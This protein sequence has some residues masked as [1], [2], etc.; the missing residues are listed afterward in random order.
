MRIEKFYLFLQAIVAVML[1]GACSEY[2]DI[3]TAETVMHSMDM[4]ASAL[5]VSRDDKKSLTQG[6][7]KIPEMQSKMSMD[8][9]MFC[10]YTSVAGINLQKDTMLAKHSRGY[11]VTTDSFYDSYDL[12]TYQYASTETFAGLNSVAATSI[13]PLY[14]D[15][16]VKMVT[17]WSTDRFW[18]GFIYNN[19][20]FAYAPY[21]PVGLTP[22]GFAIAGWPYFHYSVPDDISEQSDLLVSRNEIWTGGVPGVDYANIDVPGD[23]NEPDSIRFDHVCTGIRFAIGDK[24][25]PG[26]IKK[27]EIKNVY[28]EADYWYEDEAWHNLSVIRSFSLEKDFIIQEGE[29]NKILNSKDIFMLIPQ[30]TPS[31]AMIEITIDDGVEHVISISIGNETWQKGHTVTYYLSTYDDKSVYVLAVDPSDEEVSY[32]GGIKNLNISSYKQ[33]YY[34]SQIPVPW[35]LEYTYEIPGQGVSAVQT[36]VSEIITDITFNGNGSVLGENNAIEIAEQY[37]RSKSWRNLHTANLRKAAQVGS[38]ASPYDLTLGKPTANCYVISAPGH[39]KFP[40]VYG[41]ALKANGDFNTDAYGTNTFVDHRDVKINNP[42]IYLTNGG[43]NVPD[44]ACI[45]W[46]DAPQLVTPSSVKLDDDKHYIEFEIERNNIC[47]GNCLLAVRDVN[48]NIMWSWH[49]WVTDHDMEKTVEVHNYPADGGALTS[50]FMDIP[51]GYCSPD[52]RVYD[53]YKIHIKVKQ[54]ETGGKTAACDFYQTSADSLYEYG[55]NCLFYQWGRK[56]PMIGSN[57]MGNYRKPYYDSEY[58]W[59]AQQKTVTTGNGIKTPYIF[60]Y[61]TTK[62]CWAT[63]HK[64][65]FWNKG[66]SSTVISNLPVNKTIYDPTPQYYSVQCDAAVTGFLMYGGISSN[67]SEFNIRGGFDNGWHFYTLGWHMGPTILFPAMGWLNNASSKGG[68]IE[69]VNECPAYWSSGSLANSAKIQCGIEYGGNG[70]PRISTHNASNCDFG[71]AI[72]FVRNEE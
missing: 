49:I 40:L 8:G 46:Q 21:H 4:P 28:G 60:Y 14:T 57:G 54:T 41:N 68:K 6:E 53:S 24:M 56:D 64:V 10:R 42:Y 16:E 12:Y 31:D 51:L 62:K 7:W 34:G 37:P 13:L 48:N 47:E 50:Y 23:Y 22:T 52:M 29:S 70:N 32:D 20:F 63:S 3:K 25:A 1:F 67:S 38:S 9:K 58:T 69:E 15:Q 27:I 19:S 55:R 33:S 35:T 59:A 30:R 44:N 36:N 71:Q 61:N 65:E 72:M 5:M 11:A 66:Y 17:N 39:Y 26:T 2:I 43:A 18:P 45:V